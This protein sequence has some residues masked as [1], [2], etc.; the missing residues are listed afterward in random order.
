MNAK[1][2]HGKWVNTCQL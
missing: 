2:P 1:E